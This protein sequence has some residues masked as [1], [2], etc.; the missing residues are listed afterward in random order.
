MWDNYSKKFSTYVGYL[1][2]GNVIDEIHS[3]TYIVSNDFPILVNSIS[4][5]AKRHS[6]NTSDF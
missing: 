4:V 5:S 1:T 6:Y 3:I 2:I